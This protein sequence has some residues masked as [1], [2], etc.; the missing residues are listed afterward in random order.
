M[1]AKRQ[2][3]VSLVL[4]YLPV[5]F[6]QVISSFAMTCESEA[7]YRGLEKGSW[8]PP[9]WMFAPVWALLYI[10]MAVSVWLVYMTPKETPKR[11]LSFA[12]FFVQ[13]FFNGVWSFLF[14][15]FQ[16]PGLALIDLSVLLVFI[17]LMGVT[18]FRVRPLAGLLVL[19]YFFWSA[20]ALT[21]N[22][23]IWWL[24]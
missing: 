2:K 24:N 16:S 10:L 23:A 15:R 14:F 5:L 21:L 18:F 7:W 3:F 17:V 20:Y 12:L 19:P 22:G 13:L 4:W 6:V 1:Q 8:T 11:R 9:G